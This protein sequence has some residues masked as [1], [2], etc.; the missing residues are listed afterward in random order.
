M[1]RIGFLL[2][3]ALA[4]GSTP[5]AGAA[6]ATARATVGE[7]IAGSRRNA[8]VRAAELVMPA[9]VSISVT[10]TRVVRENPFLSFFPDEFFER[11]YPQTE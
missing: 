6:P 7:A 4:W 11:F 8:L 5:P 2:L 3:V 1:K 9:V 10:R